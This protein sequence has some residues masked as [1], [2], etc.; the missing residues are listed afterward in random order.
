M[1]DKIKKTTKDAYSKHTNWCWFKRERETAKRPTE[2][3][4]QKKRKTKFLLMTL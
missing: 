2:I 1:S 4:K 3:I